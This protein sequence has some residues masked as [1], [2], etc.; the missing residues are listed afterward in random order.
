M[1]ELERRHGEER[2]DDDRPQPEQRPQARGGVGPRTPERAYDGPRRRERPREERGGGDEHELEGAERHVLVGEDALAREVQQVVVHD[3]VP[4]KAGIAM[5]DE[6]VP[7]QRD[8]RREQRAP[9]WH[10]RRERTLAAPPEEERDHDARSERPEH[11]LGERGE[12]EGSVEER[13]R[14]APRTPIREDEARVREQDEEDEEQV[15]LHEPPVEKDP[16]VR[17]HHE[18]GEQAEPRPTEQHAESCGDRRDTD[19][20]ECRGQARGERRDPTDAEAYAH[21]PVE[22]RRLVEVPHAVDPE[23]DPVAAPRHRLRHGGVEAFRRIEQRRAA[24]TDHEEPESDD[25]D[26][27]RDAPH[28]PML[29]EGSTHSSSS[30]QAT[31]TMQSAG[32]RLRNSAS[33]ASRNASSRDSSVTLTLYSG[34]ENSGYEPSSSSG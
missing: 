11:V 23:R 10:P 34:F 16:E 31:R 17:A 29:P 30:R 22:E 5:L 9:P 7:R 13:E 32:K 21:E 6:E 15:G 4:E 33:A 1:R 28:A 26:A 19:G 24:E 18:P 20:G 2:D 27:E 12:A 3:R 25:D 8:R 14:P